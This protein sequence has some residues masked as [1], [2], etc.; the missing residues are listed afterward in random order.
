[1]SQQDKFVPTATP[2]KITDGLARGTYVAQVRAPDRDVEGLLLGVIYATAE[3][4]PDDLG[5]WFEAWAERTFCFSITSRSLP[6]WVRLHPLTVEIDAPP[7]VTIALAK[8]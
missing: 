8:T 4:A 2:A 5:A 3:E 6:V 1:M 7:Q